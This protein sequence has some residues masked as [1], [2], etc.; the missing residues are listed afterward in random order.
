M[1]NYHF[2]YPFFTSRLN[3]QFL[4]FSDS[5]QAQN[6]KVVV[7]NPTPTTKNSDILVYQSPPSILTCEG[8]YMCH[9]IL[10]HHFVT[11][12]QVF[13]VFAL[14][15]FGWWVWQ[16]LMWRSPPAFPNA[17]HYQNLS[18][19]SHRRHL[20]DKGNGTQQDGPCII[21]RLLVSSS[22]AS[23]PCLR[24]ALNRLSA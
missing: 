21:R 10:F 7:S 11:V 15:C 24:F 1:P 6:L 22:L 9:L 13:W 12:R 14:F 18:G 16:G 4:R 5:L 20:E 3:H 17:F 19:S 2:C 23:V 8:F